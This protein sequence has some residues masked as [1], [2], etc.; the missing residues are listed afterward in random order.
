MYQI[1]LGVTFDLTELPPKLTIQRYSLNL[2][3]V[4]KDFRLSPPRKC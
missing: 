1:R 4:S 3:Q 2:C